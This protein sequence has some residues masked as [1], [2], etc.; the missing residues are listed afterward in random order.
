LFLVLFHGLSQAVAARFG[1]K[2]E[3]SKSFSL[4]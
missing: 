4:Q 1:T 2:L 3:G